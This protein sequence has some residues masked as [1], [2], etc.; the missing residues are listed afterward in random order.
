MPVSTLSDTIDPLIQTFRHWRRLHR[1]KQSAAGDMLGVS[2]ATIS[3]WERGQGEITWTQRRR[4]REIVGRAGVRSDSLARHL[5]SRAL[6]LAGLLD[7]DLICLAVSPEAAAAHGM[8]PQDMVGVDFRPL[9]PEVTA[10][11]MDRLD[12]SGFYVGEVASARAVFPVPLLRGGMVLAEHLIV[13]YRS[14]D[15]RILSIITSAV[16]GPESA[17]RAGTLDVVHLDAI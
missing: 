9:V 2:Q 5:V 15:D 8:T 16:L 3:R 1:V 17:D 4:I 10:D 13:P 11:V 14:A 7:R 12:R 6:G